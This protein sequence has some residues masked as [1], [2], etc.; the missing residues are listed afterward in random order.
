VTV[1]AIASGM[2]VVGYPAVVLHR[3]VGGLL[4][5]AFQRCAATGTHKLPM[6]YVRGA[7]PNGLGVLAMR[8]SV[9]SGPD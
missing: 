5:V 3:V 7:V 9:L 1:P 2:Q 8:S 6:R 4:V